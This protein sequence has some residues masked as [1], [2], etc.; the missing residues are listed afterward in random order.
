LFS[1]F[2]TIQFPRAT[3]YRK[4]PDASQM[5]VGVSGAWRVALEAVFPEIMEPIGELNPAPQPRGRC[6]NL[7]LQSRGSANPETQLSAY[8]EGHSDVRAG[9]LLRKLSKDSALAISET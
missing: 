8:D 5:A 9:T 3:F 2:E 6:Q 1:E 7:S 4:N